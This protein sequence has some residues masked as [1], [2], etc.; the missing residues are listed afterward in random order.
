MWYDGS[1]KKTN[2]VK[3]QAD[4]RERESKTEEKAPSSELFVFTERKGEPL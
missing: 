1:K 2:C 3:T 4:E